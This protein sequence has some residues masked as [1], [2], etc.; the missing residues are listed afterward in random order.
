MVGASPC[1][2]PQGDAPTIVRSHSDLSLVSFDVL[3]VI[4]Y[5]LPI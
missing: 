4:D 5:P 1:G 3:T 2:R